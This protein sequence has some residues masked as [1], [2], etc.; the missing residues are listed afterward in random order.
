MF[1]LWKYFRFDFSY[2]AI[3]F[4]KIFKSKT[5][6]SWGYVCFSH[7]RCGCVQ[8][9]AVKR[10]QLSVLSRKKMAYWQLSC[11]NSAT[12]NK[13]SIHMSERKSVLKTAYKRSQNSTITKT[14]TLH[15]NRSFKFIIGNLVMSRRT[16]I[17]KTQN[18]STD[19]SVCVNA[20]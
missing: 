6:Q 12:S 8:T 11:T 18:D 5:Y 13:N 2:A 9:M 17:R 20:I 15:R 1:Y 16:F 4:E 19:C 10:T 3:Y 7:L 14:S